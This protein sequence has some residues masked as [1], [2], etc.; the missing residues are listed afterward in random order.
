[1]GALQTS[2]LG[3]FSHQEVSAWTFPDWLTLIGFPLVGV[4]LFLAWRHATEIKKTAEEAGRAATSGLEAA[5]AARD[6]SESSKAAAVAAK[7]GADAARVAAEQARDA[8]AAAREAIS[9]TEKK[10]SDQ[11]LLMLIGQVQI[12]LGELDRAQSGDDWDRVAS[13][14]IDVAGELDGMLKSGGSHKD[15]LGLLEPSISA[16]GDLKNAIYER[17]EDPEM[18]AIPLRNQLTLVRAAASRIMGHMRV[19]IQEEPRA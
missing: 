10:L 9:R 17:E 2:I 15:L 5:E 6:G 13:E 11:N 3:F 18:A 8:A 7:G 14:W 12:V 19:S 1:V 4:G 16:A